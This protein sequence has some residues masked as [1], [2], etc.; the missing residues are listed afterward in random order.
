MPNII[1]HLI[2]CKFGN[3]DFSSEAA[4]MSPVSLSANVYVSYFPKL[5]LLQMLPNCDAN[6]IK[7][8]IKYKYRAYKNINTKP[9]TKV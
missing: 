9:K 1:V 8:Y 2:L 5:K 6:L 3:T 4:D 7:F